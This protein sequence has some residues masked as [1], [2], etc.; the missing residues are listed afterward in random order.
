LTDLLIDIK[1]VLT[2]IPESVIL[3]DFALAPQL[4]EAFS[5]HAWPLALQ[6]AGFYQ[7][8]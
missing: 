7:L 1:H 3:G 6:L 2:E 8:L 4:R 5:I